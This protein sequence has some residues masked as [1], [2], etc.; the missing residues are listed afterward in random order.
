MKKLTSILMI[1]MAAIFTISLT[2]C[3][4]ESI[5]Y[6]LEGT[7]QGDMY[8][9]HTWNGRV[10]NA[11]Y[12]E[13]YFETSPFKTRSGRGYWYDKYSNAPWDYFESRTTWRVRDGIIY[14]TLIDDGNFEIVI[15]DY[16]LDEDRFWG[17]ID[18]AGGSKKFTMYHIDSPHW[19]NYEYGYGYND[20]Y[21]DYYYGYAKSRANGDSIK[22]EKPVRSI[23]ID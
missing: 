10:Y 22:M 12:S 21:Y 3:E 16:H 20:Y 6:D 18:Y 14:I 8:Q 7:W 9:Q 11:S 23:R 5:A 15:S 13:I 2:S 19:N 1:A 17:Y 4:D